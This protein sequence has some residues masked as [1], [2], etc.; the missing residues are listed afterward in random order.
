MDVVKYFEEK[1]RMLDSLGRIS[2]QCHGIKCSNCP[3]YYQN[4]GGGINCGELEIV[5]PEQAI[6]IVEKWSQEHPGKTMLQ[7][8][9]EKYPKARLRDNGTPRNVCPYRLG[10]EEV[11]RCTHTD[12]V[13]C[14][15]RPL[16]E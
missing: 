5:H 12:C 6:E 2:G 16:E 10:Y 13:K 11:A 1:R 15:N 7:D 9:L 3:L 14:W 4:H 8:F